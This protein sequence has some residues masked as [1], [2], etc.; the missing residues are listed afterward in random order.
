MK[1]TVEKLVLGDLAT[2]TYIVTD[3]ESGECAVVDPAIESEELL[4]SLENKNVKYILLT[5]GHFDHIGGVNAV[6]EQT[7]AKVVI[8]TKEKPFLSEIALN[9]FSWKYRDHKHIKAILA[10]IL[11][12]DGTEI[13]FG[14]GKIKV[15][16]TPGHTM[17]GVCYIFDDDRILFSGDTLFNLSAGRTDL[18]TGNA[19]EELMS[20]AKIGALEGDY[21]VYPGHEAETTLEFERENNRY[22]KTRF[23]NKL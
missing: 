20:L 7:G 8:H 10:D 17:G 6:K 16:H 3:T 14:D 5:H 9:L 19:R 11:T 21:K 23:R 1:I 15:M 18:P 12:D 2:N 4:Q 22:M 13:P